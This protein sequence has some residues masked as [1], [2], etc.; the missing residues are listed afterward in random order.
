MARALR[1]FPALAA[2][3]CV[4][5]VVA[6]F[7]VTTAPAAE[8]W[9]AAPDYFIRNFTLFFLQYGLPGVFVDNPY[10]P[11]I[12]GSLWTLSYEVICYAGGFVVG[13]LGLFHAPRASALFFL[14]VVG[15]LIALRYIP[16]HVRLE[17]LARLALPFV[18]G[19]ALFVW[20]A[21]I[22]LSPWV[23]AALALAAAV[24]H[25][26]PVFE[27]V[28]ILTLSYA[29]F[30]VGLMRA[31]LLLAY[32]RLGD[33]SYGLYVYAFPVQQL[34]AHAG[35]RDPLVNIAVSLPVAM[36]CAVLS[37]VLVERVALRYKPRGGEIAPP[38]FSRA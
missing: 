22:P 15:S 9:M 32:N 17:V 10:G 30:V 25:G 20:R 4:T 34:A 29:T 19:S 11:V 31:P 14:V 27:P 7:A 38:P 6:G 1:L 36:I 8:F 13:A 5:L 33:Y 18:F 2:V 23:A 37:W 24:L 12:N 35:V 3:L 21:R 16:T 26:S 28:F